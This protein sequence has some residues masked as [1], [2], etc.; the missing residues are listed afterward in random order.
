M[1]LILLVAAMVQPLWFNSQHAGDIYT[2]TPMAHLQSDCRCEL[3]VRLQKTGPSGSSTSQQQGVINI[4][5][6]AD[7]SLTQMRFNLQPGDKVVLSMS[8][9]DGQRL[10]LENTLSLP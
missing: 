7:V 4:I 8:L 10:R 2:V 3:Q 6:N 9:T 5:G 1:F